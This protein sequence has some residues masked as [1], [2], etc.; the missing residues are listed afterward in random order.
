MRN[1]GLKRSDLCRMQQFNDALIEKRRNS[2]THR[3]LPTYLPTYLH[4]HPP[5]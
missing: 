2:N 3:Y 4:T 5:T 1:V